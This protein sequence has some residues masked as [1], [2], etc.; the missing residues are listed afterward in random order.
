MPRTRQGGSREP[1]FFGA[2]GEHPCDHKQADH[3]RGSVARRSGEACWPSS[4]KPIN[5]PLLGAP[6]PGCPL[7]LGEESSP[8]TALC[9]ALSGG[10]LG[11]WRRSWSSA[12]VQGLV[13]FARFLGRRQDGCAA[14]I[15]ALKPGSALA[16][17]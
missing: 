8:S 17:I 6:P 15:E 5:G 13:G 7:T 9:N 1:S 14:S 16:T 11:G 10:L 12:A 2:C 4:L 3:R